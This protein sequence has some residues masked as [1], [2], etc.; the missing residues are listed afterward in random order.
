[1]DTDDPC[2]VYPLGCLLVRMSE[3]RNLGHLQNDIH[4]IQCT[5]LGFGQAEEC[6]N[7]GQ[8]HPRRKEE[9][10]AVPERVENI[11]QSLGYSELSEPSKTLG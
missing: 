4:F 3:D 5:S 10:G 2:E 6:P 11:W 1:M 9:P 8:K 7:S